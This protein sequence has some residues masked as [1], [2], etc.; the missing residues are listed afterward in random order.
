ML[1]G[2]QIEI[3]TDHK[4]LAHKNLLMLSNRV[5]QWQLIIE[6]YD[7]KIFHIP[8][9]NNVVKDALSRLSTMDKVSDKNILTKDVQK[10]YAH[11]Q[12]INNQCLLDI[13]VFTHA[14]QNELSVLMSNLKRKVCND[15]E[16]L[17]T[18]YNT[19]KIV[20]YNNNMYVSQLLREHMLN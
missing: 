7:P 20:M 12:D 11:T 13:S 16:H 10:N 18:M 9:L 6:E 14:Q 8:G 15:N 1:L 3:H 4:N 5:I 19:H 17:C 2:Y